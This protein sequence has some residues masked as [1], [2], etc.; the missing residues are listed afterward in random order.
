MIKLRE[1]TIKDQKGTIKV[2]DR[3]KEELENELEVTFPRKMN[4]KSSLPLAS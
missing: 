4:D 2:T 1:N 3:H